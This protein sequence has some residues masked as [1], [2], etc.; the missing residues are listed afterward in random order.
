M[1]PSHI[2]LNQSEWP[3]SCRTCAQ[4]GAGNIGRARLPLPLVSERSHLK[5]PTEPTQPGTL[6]PLVRWPA[7]SGSNLMWQVMPVHFDKFSFGSTQID[8]RVFDF[9]LVIDRGEI[10]KRKKKAS[11]RY[12]DAYGHTPVSIEENIS[13]ALPPPGCRHRSSGPASCDARSGKGRTG[14][15]SRAGSSSDERRYRHPQSRRSKYEC[16]SSHNL[17]SFSTQPPG[18]S[19]VFSV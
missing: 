4:R 8:G 15:E 16:H 11:K 17:L 12:R 9:D 13:V 2:G 3:P 1:S 6:A 19:N 7:K 5:W 14:S 18:L 10:R